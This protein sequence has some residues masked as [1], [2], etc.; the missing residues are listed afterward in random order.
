MYSRH[1]LVVSTAIAGGFALATDW[2][3]LIVVYGALVGTLI[4]LDHFP[5]ARYNRGDWHPLYFCL[6]HP[7]H[8]IVD[9]SEIFDDTDVL[10][11][12]RL[13]THAILG[14]ILVAIT[15]PIHSGLG[16][17]TAV[18]IYVHIIMDLIADLTR[19]HH[20]VSTAP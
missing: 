13:F 11:S 9:Q 16:L 6:T 19:N 17:V 5:I 20:Q 2:G 3:L 14:G 15:T 7:R 8:A 18:I 4:D 12:Q 1:H 10:D